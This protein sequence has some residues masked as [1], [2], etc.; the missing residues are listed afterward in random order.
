[1]AQDFHAAFGLG[2]D[3]RRINV[4]DASGVALAAIQALYELSRRQQAEIATL[5]RDLANQA[6]ELEAFR[7]SSAAAQA[8]PDALPGRPADGRPRSSAGSV[9]GDR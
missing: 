7:A 9:P 1:M 2:G 4:V 6:R 5:S 3:D 8:Q